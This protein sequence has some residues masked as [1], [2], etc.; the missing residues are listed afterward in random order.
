M[1]I[2]L[3]F[4]YV[5]FFKKIHLPE[6]ENRM[7]NPFVFAFLRKAFAKWYV[8]SDSKDWLTDEFFPQKDFTLII[9]IT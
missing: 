5:Y 9:E 4:Q 2:L 8:K 6:C 3:K 1:N 7:E